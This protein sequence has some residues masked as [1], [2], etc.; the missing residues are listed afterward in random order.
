[1]LDPSAEDVFIGGS[2]G[3]LRRRTSAAS[4]S[5]L[6]AFKRSMISPMFSNLGYSQF[7]QFLYPNPAAATSAPALLAQM[8]RYNPYANSFVPKPPNPFG[9]GFG[10]DRLLATHPHA[11]FYQRLQYQQLLQNQAVQFQQQQQQQQLQQQRLSPSP[12]ASLTHS[13]PIF[14]PMAMVSRQS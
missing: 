4:R 12:P 8:Y 6:A 11:E 7:S 3:K 13:P 2:T 1:M 10:V 14:K 9:T 5:R